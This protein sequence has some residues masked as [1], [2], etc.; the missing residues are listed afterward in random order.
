[1]ISKKKN[2]KT[3]AI[4]LC[5]VGSRRLKNKLFL[6]L[7]K[8]FVLKIFLD[9]LKKSKQVNKIIFATT[10]KHK[11]NIIEKFA[12]DNGYECFRGS[13]TNVLKRFYEAIKKF[14]RNYNIVVRANADCP[15]FMPTI[16]DRDIKRFVKNKFDVYSPFHKNIMPFGFSFVIFKK[17]TV[18]KIFKKAKLLKYKEHI[19]NY[20]FDNDNKFKI[21]L[22]PVNELYKAP[23]I[24]ITLDTKNDFL[25]IKKIFNKIK[26]VKI[27]NQPSLL[28][29]LFK[30]N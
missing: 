12:K 23:K 19:E 13:E 8:Q 21:L 22:S 20:C 25:K 30:K 29:N 26:N 24:R 1:M 27:S 3:L 7:N 28:I 16:L 17:N 4:I 6:K 18:F 10:I 9:R 5:R 2:S 15:I 11:D 14:G